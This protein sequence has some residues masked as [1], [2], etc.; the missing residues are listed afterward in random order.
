[1]SS[2]ASV[3]AVQDSIR[4]TG[5]LE[6]GL[7]VLV[8]LSGGADSVCLLHA[9]VEIAGPSALVAL[10][11]NHGLRSAA[12][13]DEAFCAE[14]ASALGV[15]FEAAR[16][17][18]EPGG[19]VEAAAREG[20]YRLAEQA[21][22]RAGLDR[23]ATGHTA[24]DQVETV[25]YR[26]ASSPGRRPLL[27]MRR[28][29]GRLIRPLLEVTAEQT[30]AYC[31]A[32]GLGWREDETNADRAYARNRLRLDVVPALREIHP[33]AGENVLAS[34]DEL[35]EEAEVLDAAVDEAMSRIGAGGGP[36]SVESARLAELPRAL[37]RLVLRR[38][39]EAAAGAP[40][41]LRSGRIEEIEALA[42]RGGTAA[43]DIGGG[44]RAVSE[45]GLLR[46]TVDPERPSP[47]PVTMA[48]PGRCR[49]GTWEVACEL[50]GRT[51]EDLGSPDEAV[52]DADRL[53]PELTV[54]AWRDGD[55]MQPL[56]LDGTK[57][58]QD[59]FTDRK[60]PRGLRRALPVVESGGEI[61]WVAGVAV[62]GRFSLKG[63]A[64]RAARLRARVVAGIEV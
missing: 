46:F 7:R 52:V 25:L 41:P 39:A 59:L 24:D 5:L 21:R 15:P 29:N 37:R 43:L 11:V 10:H 36:P 50:E 54:R 28:R 48:V 12:A 47:D 4:E 45:Y 32:A 19:S 60:V 30:R 9:L 55:R 61:V 16:L 3:T 42:A 49:F 6:P 63:D 35:R 23:I 31:C 38:L 17:S 64:P 26:L 44:V 8:M 22:A 33:A 56:G 2:G 20:R 40:V 1:M 51:P 13:D 57:T 58:L 62:S 34:V 14:L 27:G 53:A 18:L